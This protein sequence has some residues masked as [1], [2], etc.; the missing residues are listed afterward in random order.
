MA[1]VS[2]ALTGYR[3][4]A[5]RQEVE[6]APVTV[7]LGRNNSGKSALVRAPVVLGT[8][9]R[10]RSQVPLDL[11]MLAN[12]GEDMPDSFTDLVYGNR[13]HGSISV[14]LELTG[15]QERAVSMSATVQNIDEYHTQVVSSLALDLTSPRHRARLDWLPKD[16][17]VPAE[18]TV[19]VDDH[20]PVDEEIQF[21]GLLPAASFDR[22]TAFPP[23]R[24]Q[25]LT[26]FP[27]IR[28]FGPFRDRPQREYKLP[29]R[30]PTEAGITGEQAIG[31]L[32]SD[33]VRGQGTIL[34]QVNQDLAEHLPGWRLDITEQGRGYA[35]L[36]VSLTDSSLSVNLADAGT[37]VAQVL[38]IFVQ[39]AAD[40]VHAPQQPVL[41]IIEQP[42][43]HLH[44]AAHGGLADLYLTAAR[45]ADTDLRFLVET[46]SE[47][48]L[49]RL[50]R[51]IAEG[52]D[53]G[54]VA[55]YFVEHADGASTVRRINVDD[56]GNIDYWPPGV[57]SED[58]A[59][60]RAMAA[61]QMNRGDEDARGTR[62]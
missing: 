38:P 49:L 24:P 4:F 15:H 26:A 41:E 39:R 33:Y 30:T 32:I 35:V 23:F 13:P 5:T 43:L 62:P 61:A 46:H 57:F 53:P 12:F 31:M 59:E 20:V 51:R 47:T 14:E 25:V 60:T 7:V 6:L 40:I 10:T 18:Y 16:P 19:I 11:D 2:M 52:L 37:G 8:G 17:P 29:S 1:L 54:L 45:R 42:E 22:R 21:S 44:P 36:L 55:L 58:Y 27:S 9:F 34:G 56:R 50:R 28:Y 48:F 3:C